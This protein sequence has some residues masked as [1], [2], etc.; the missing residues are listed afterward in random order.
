MAAYLESTIVSYIRRHIRRMEGDG[1][2]RLPSEH[3]L[4]T[5][6]SVSRMTIRSAYLSLEE[7]GLVSS[8]Q[9]K[10][11]FAA[12]KRKTIGLSLS[13][14]TSFTDKMRELGLELETRAVACGYSKRKPNVWA[15]LG[16]GDDD[17]VFRFG[18]LRVV[19]GK[20]VALHVS[21]LKLADF[22]DLPARA[23]TVSSLFAYFREKGFERF[24]SSG[25]ILGVAFPT[26]KE[27]G[28]LQ[29]GHLVPLLTCESDTLDAVTGAVLQF[30]RILYRGDAFQYRL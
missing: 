5:R 19:E 24:S 6:F 29:V 14:E 1:P 2:G 26:K 17:R 15:A 28:F 22:P 21:Y 8:R 11:H 13:G 18:R 25:T 12:P 4:A 27:A 10:G 20:A 7:M 23:V 30:S 9:G 3:E 16:A